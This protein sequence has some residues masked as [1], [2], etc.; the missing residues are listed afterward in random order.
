MR[1]K[2]MNMTIRYP[3]STNTNIFTKSSGSMTKA[4]QPPSLAMKVIQNR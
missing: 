4:N 2:S 1:L 3:I